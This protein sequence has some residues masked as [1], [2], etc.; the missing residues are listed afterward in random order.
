MNEWPRLTSDHLPVDVYAVGQELCPHAHCVVVVA[1]VVDD[2]FHEEVAVCC[3]R[4]HD[5][6][7]TR[8]RDVVLQPTRLSD[9]TTNRQ[10]TI[11][12]HPFLPSMPLK[13]L[14]LLVITSLLIPFLSQLH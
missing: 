3:V 10:I 14:R 9:H 12:S 5:Q 6:S 1:G 8:N 4:I 13:L 7:L 11:T 2:L